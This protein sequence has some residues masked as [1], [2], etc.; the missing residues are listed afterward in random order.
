MSFLDR[1]VKG[2]LAGVQFS[3]ES[4]TTNFGRRVAVYELP[5][6]ETGVAHV[7][8]GRSSREFRIKA[9]FLG[10]DYDRERNKLIS[11][12]EKPGP[13]L[14]VHPT[15]GRSM[16]IV[17]SASIAESTAEGGMCEVEFTAVE[18]RDPLPPDTGLSLLDSVQNL[19][20]AA[21]DNLFTK[22]LTDG[23]DFLTQ[24]LFDVLDTVGRDLTI[25]NAQIGAWLAVPGNLA[26][27]IDRISRQL[28]ELIDTPRKLF[29]AID[30]FL[31][32][33][34]ASISRV[35]DAVTQNDLPAS[36]RHSA[37][38]RAMG[39]LAALGDT[40]PAIPPADTTARR[41]Q[42]INRAALILAIKSSAFA[43]A[44]AALSEI[45][46]E[47]RTEALDLSLTLAGLLSD[48]AD[49]NLDGEEV[50]AEMYESLKSLASQVEKLA[51]QSGTDGKVQ[52]ISTTDATA[53]VVLAYRLYGDAS[54]G[55]QILAR[56]PQLMHP[57]AVPASE[58]VEVLDR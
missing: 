49:S 57:G 3:T 2:S 6:S 53:L 7:D 12:F 37:L 50:S 29:D 11:A 25:L 52:L 43:N 31:G 1:Y 56:N 30:N 5:F 39:R 42:R 58:R 27:K 19:R 18:A 54:R 26:A 41:Q 4:M 32:S 17:K 16:V 38:K 22:L 48:L 51:D 47:S 10:E 45:P 20:D 14:L 44:A 23:P 34:M 46:P 33:L 9:L 55:E 28:A 8:L 24:D 40:S 36:V 35:V 15:L 13:K 21:S